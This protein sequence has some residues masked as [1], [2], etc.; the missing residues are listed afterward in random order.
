ML[1]SFMVSSLGGYPPC[2]DF[3]LSVS[4]IQLFFSKG[5]SCEANLPFWSLSFLAD[6]FMC[7][8]IPK[9]LLNCWT[10]ILNLHK[11]PYEA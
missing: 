11:P 1:V 7:G 9:L 8:S 5:F 10:H 4:V 3:L 6:F 2:L